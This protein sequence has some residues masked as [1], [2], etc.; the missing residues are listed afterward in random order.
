MKLNLF[1]VWLKFR[2]PGLCWFSWIFEILYWAP[3]FVEFICNCLFKLSFLWCLKS[4]FFVTS[5][6]NC[7]NFNKTST[8]LITSSKIASNILQLLFLV[9]KQSHQKWNN[10]NCLASLLITMLGDYVCWFVSLTAFLLG[11]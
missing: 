4:K 3:D 6:E 11:R 1:T 8:P 2:K 7:Q 5:L 10:F 9:E